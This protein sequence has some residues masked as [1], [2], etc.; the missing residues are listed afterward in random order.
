MAVTRFGVSLEDETLKALDKY[1]EENKFAN[2][3]RALRFLIEKHLVEKKWQCDNI[4]A[5]VITLVYDNSRTDIVQ[6]SAELMQPYHECILSVQHYWL[7][8]QNSMDV[9][10]IKGASRILTEL[11]DK[12]FSI[13]GLQHGKLT[14][15]KA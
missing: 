12:L 9:L 14:M 11:S 7:N 1:V 2:R 13:K 10:V 5:G 15:S 6:H 4:V 3:S 8:E